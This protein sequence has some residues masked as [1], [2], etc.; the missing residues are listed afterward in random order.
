MNRETDANRKFY[1]NIERVDSIDTLAYDKETKTVILQL[2]DGMDW[3][4]EVYHLPLLQRKLN[5]YLWFV[6]SKQYL[7]KYPLA[8]RVN[9]TISFL[10]KESDNCL[11]LL[12]N[13]DYV[14]QD[15][16]D[17]V[18]LTIEHGTKETF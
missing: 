13:L 18:I 9:I 12:S 15:S 5:N 1:M 16:F 4:D 11:K 8:E 6:E 10:F 17:N 3:S 14:I 7:T 2:A